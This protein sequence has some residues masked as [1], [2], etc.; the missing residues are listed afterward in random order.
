MI[1]GWVAGEERVYISGHVRSVG[2]KVIEQAIAHSGA[3]HGLASRRQIRISHRLR[4][5]V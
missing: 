5:A 2:R 4:Y 1:L 3:G